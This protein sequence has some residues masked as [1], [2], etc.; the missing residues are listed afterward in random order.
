MSP[1]GCTP[2]PRGNCSPTHPYGELHGTMCRGQRPLF[3]LQLLAVCLGVDTGGLGPGEAGQEPKASGDGG[4]GEGATRAFP[5]APALASPHVTPARGL[6]PA[7]I[8]P[9]AVSQ[10]L[11]C[12]LQGP[13]AGDQEERL[14][15]GPDARLQPHLRPMERSR[16]D[17]VS[18]S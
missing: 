14:L 10:A 12:L 8:C 11:R 2:S 16:S 13:R 3:L 5:P 18:I 9:E 17:V 4:S 1:G 7:P 15:R 6:P